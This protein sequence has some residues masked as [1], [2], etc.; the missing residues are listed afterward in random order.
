MR[1]PAQSPT[2]VDMDTCQL[3]TARSG[4]SSKMPVKDAGRLARARSITAGVMSTVDT[5]RLR[6]SE[7][8]MSVTERAGNTSVHSTVVTRHTMMPTA[9]SI[10]GKDSAVAM[11]SSPSE[12]TEA[13]T[14]A[15]QVASAKD[16]KRSAPMPAMSPTLSPT[17]SAIVAGLRGSSSGMS[18]STLPTR[19]APTSAA[20][21]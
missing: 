10:S 16:P 20:L 12:D 15:A 8:S 6:L 2:T 7:D 21:V 9:V 17:L 1:R 14:S 3:C 18:C 13:T 11:W 19:S 4:S 5:T